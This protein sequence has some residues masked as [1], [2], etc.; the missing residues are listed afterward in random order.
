[1]AKTYGELKTQADANSQAWHT[2]DAEGRKQLEESNKSL[3]GQM[4]S[5]TSGKSSFDS[6][7][8]KWNSNLENVSYIDG[9]GN[10][11][12]GYYAPDYSSMINHAV[13]TNADYDMVQ[14]LQDRRNEK[15]Q[16]N[17]SLSKYVNDDTYNKANRYIQKGRSEERIGNTYADILSAN[18][19]E[20]EALIKQAISGISGQRQQ[21][22]RSYEDV[23]RQ[24][25]IDKRNNEKNLPQQLAVMG[26]TGGL[27][28]SA[29]LDLGTSYEQALRQSEADKINTLSEFDRAIENA[30]LTGN[31]AMAQNARDIMF[32]KMGAYE[33]LENQLRED[34]R[35]QQQLDYQKERDTINDGFTERQLA[36]SEIES[37]FNRNDI[38]YQ[39]KL[40]LAQTAAQY[41]DNSKLRQL[42]IN[43]VTYQKV[44]SSGGGN[45]SYRNESNNEQ[46]SEDDL[47]PRKSA[48]NQLTS[49]YNFNLGT[50]SSVD[51]FKKGAER[52]IA[53]GYVTQY[54]YEKWL[55]DNGLA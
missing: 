21:A 9:S 15:I 24:L 33:R 32:E 23:A 43:P 22:A 52:L 4:D 19:E 5:L 45:H 13:D 53:G 34:E 44:I 50:N 30:R 11:K 28:E 18:K 55:K 12:D 35:Y 29:L 14:N 48:Y 26:Y 41:G 38:S 8:G 42:G 2:A 31:I 46:E 40:E 37:E 6:S 1:M 17:P 49:L 25:Y 7:T 16:N 54:E 20:N 51:S 10:K 3:Y 27:S 36:L 47:M 39:R